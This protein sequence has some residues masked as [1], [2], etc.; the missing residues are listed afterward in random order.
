MKSEILSCIL[1]IAILLIWYGILEILNKI[2]KKKA[3]KEND[4]QDR[5]SNLYWVGEVDKDGIPCGKWTYVKAS[6]WEPVFQLTIKNWKAV[7]N[8]IFYKAKKTIIIWSFNLTVENDESWGSHKIRYNSID[9][10][11]S[12]YLNWVLVSKMTWKKWKLKWIMKNYTNWYV[13]SEINYNKKIEKDWILYYPHITY[14]STGKNKWEYIYKDWN[15]IIIKDLIEPVKLKDKKGN[16]IW[17]CKLKNFENIDKNWTWNW[18]LYNKND[19]LIYEWHFIKWYFYWYWSLFFH[20]KL[21]YK[22]YMI[23]WKMQWRWTAYLNWNP[24]LSWY[25][26]K[27]KYKWRYI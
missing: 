13:S 25:W 27:W 1:F 4:I 18:L 21:L 15:E 3:E 11:W 2:D 7:W 20:S 23:H 12:V 9:W 5:I 26:K 19:E 10:K 6:T 8:G 17:E 16:L 24:I 22:W 14:S